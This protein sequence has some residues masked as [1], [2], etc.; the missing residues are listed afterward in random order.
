[1]TVGMGDMHLGVDQVIA[2]DVGIAGEGDPPVGLG[3]VVFTLLL[4]AVVELLT[5]I[6][7]ILDLPVGIVVRDVGVVDVL[8]AVT[9]IRLFVSVS[10]GNSGEKEENDCDLK[11]TRV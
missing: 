8:L 6:V 7:L 10:G 3:V 1:M 5:V 11:S 4:L 9:S 2:L